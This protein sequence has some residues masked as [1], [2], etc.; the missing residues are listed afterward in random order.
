MTETRPEFRTFY[1]KTVTSL[2]DRFHELTHRDPASL[3]ITALQVKGT[4]IP[5]QLPDPAQYPP[6]TTAEHREA[7]R[8]RR[9][10][11]PALPPPRPAS[12]RA[13]KAG[14]TWAQI[15]AAFVIPTAPGYPPE[16]RGGAVSPGP[17][18]RKGTP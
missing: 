16:P 18:N 2:P 11:R 17:D 12:T 15:A 14:A 8:A 3:A 5:G 7:T 1:G 10:H 9:A 6:L 4:Y 13:V